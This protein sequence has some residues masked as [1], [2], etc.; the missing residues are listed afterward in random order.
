MLSTPVCGV[1]IRKEVA[2][3]REAPLRRMA[4]AVGNTPHEQRGNGMPIAAD[5]ITDFS[6]V[7]DKWRANVRC[8]MKA[9]MTPA[10]RKPSRM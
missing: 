3:A 5:F 6:P 7:P 10:I 4:I 8:G 2:A 9:C 1:E